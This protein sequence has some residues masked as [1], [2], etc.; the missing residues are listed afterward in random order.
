MKMTRFYI[1][2]FLFF[3]Y[4]KIIVLYISHCAINFNAGAM[5][6]YTNEKVLL[7]LLL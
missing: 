5:S 3:I 7:Y 1:F 2:F 4:I 6:A